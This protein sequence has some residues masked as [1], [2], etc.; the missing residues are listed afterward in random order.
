M[1]EFGRCLGRAQRGIHL[2]RVVELLGF[3]LRVEV[4]KIAEPFVE[5]MCGRQEFI[6]VAKVVFAELGGCVTLGLEDFRQGRIDL[7]DAARRTGD[8]NG[9]HPRADRKLPRNE[10]RTSRSTAG[11]CIVI[12]EKHA[13]LGNTVNRRRSTHHAVRVHADI[14]SADI[15]TED[16]E[17]VRLCG[18]CL[19]SA[20][21]TSITLLPGR[22]YFL[23][24]CYAFFSCGFPFQV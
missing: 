10:G 9:G 6:A 17:D 24:N 7:L 18:L 3:L 5:A 2:P 15:V 21:S 22:E 23:G 19:S 13:F 14:P 11:L 16:D 1:R 20:A 8:A 12:G 4:V